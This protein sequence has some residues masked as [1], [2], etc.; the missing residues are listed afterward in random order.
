MHANV[1]LTI[2]CLYHTASSDPLIESSIHKRTLKSMLQSIQL[3]M[4]SVWVWD[5]TFW[6]AGS[7]KPHL[8]SSVTSRCSHS[9]IWLRYPRHYTW[10]IDGDCAGLSAVGWFTAAIS[11]QHSIRD[12]SPSVAS[13]VTDRGN[14]EA[15]N[16]PSNELSQIIGILFYIGVICSLIG[17]FVTPRWFVRCFN[18]SVLGYLSMFSYTW[19]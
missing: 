2:V 4:S 14:R 5:T 6:A 7:R 8:I 15:S 13:G 12:G 16:G 3:I 18:L 9:I 1:D 17:A 11:S 19:D 10:C